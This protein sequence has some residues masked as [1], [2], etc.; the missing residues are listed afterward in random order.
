[1]MVA[2]FQESVLGYDKQRAKSEILAFGHSE[3]TI[4]DI[5][6]FIDAYDPKSRTIGVVGSN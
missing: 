2:A 4:N 1:M 5:R 3:N 6:R